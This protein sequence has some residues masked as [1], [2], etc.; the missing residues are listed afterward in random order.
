MFLIECDQPLAR[1]SF[2]FDPFTDIQWAVVDSYPVRLVDRQ[3]FYGV[4][5]H[6]SDIFEIES[7]HFVFLFQQCSERI[8]IVACKSSTDA[9]SHMTISH[10]LAVNFAGQ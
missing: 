3:K 8:H 7:Q 9:Q 10:Y 4:S 1:F 5:I 6:Q 2:T